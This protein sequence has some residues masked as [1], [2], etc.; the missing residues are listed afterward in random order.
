MSGLDLSMSRQRQKSRRKSQPKRRT[1]KMSDL[2]GM[3]NTKNVHAGLIE[4][5]VIYSNGSNNT[6]GLESRDGQN[7]NQ[8]KDQ[9]GNIKNNMKSVMSSRKS[10]F[11]SRDFY[12]EMMEDVKKS[13]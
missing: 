2:L 13:V 10:I 7:S 12:N 5:R 1:Q 8:N 11:I 6:G 4:K 9:D 3:V